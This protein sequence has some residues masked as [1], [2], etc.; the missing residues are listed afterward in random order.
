MVKSGAAI[1]QERNAISMAMAHSNNG[2]DAHDARDARDSRDPYSRPPDTQ[3]RGSRD[4]D[5]PMP[6]VGGMG[7]VPFPGRGPPSTL[8][9]YKRLYCGNVPPDCTEERLLN[10]ISRAYER[11]GVPKEPGNV[12]INAYINPE[13]GYGFVEFRSPEE[14]ANALQL[15]NTSFDGFFLRIRRPKD[16]VPD[17]SLGVPDMPQSLPAGQRAAGPPGVMPPAGG[18]AQTSI[19]DSPHK[20]FI[21]AIPTYLREDQIQ[22]LL[23]TFGQLKS[24]SLIRDSQTGFSKG[25][26]FCEFVDPSVIDAVCQALNGME[27]G[28]KKLI[29]Q[30]A[31]ASQRPAAGAVGLMPNDILSAANR[32][33]T[34]TTSVLLLLNMVTAED[35]TPQEEYDGGL[36]PPSPRLKRPG[37]PAD[38]APFFGPEI[39]AEVKEECS[40]YGTVVEVVI[41]RPI[42]GHSVPG[43]GKVFVRFDEAQ[44]ASAAQR[45]LAGRTFSERVVIA[46]FYSEESFEKKEY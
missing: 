20:L 29:V 10:F 26:A 23:K 22:D 31:A 38:L 15:D 46:T 27:I 43:V 33:P 42:E 32:D 2:R 28:D 13:R 6:A 39:V 35:L 30:R 36:P 3:S 5:R 44:Y 17:P 12:A 24:F 8:R 40:K 34:R 41:P 7:G 18:V 19:S 16:F 25:F 37:H 9:Q 45:A 11:L 21:G 4:S 1:A 14:A